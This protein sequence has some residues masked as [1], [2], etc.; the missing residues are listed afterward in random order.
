MDVVQSH[1]FL[2]QHPFP[3]C[4]NHLVPLVIQHRFFQ[5]TVLSHSFFSKIIGAISALESG[6]RE[7]TISLTRIFSQSIPYAFQQLICII[8]YAGNISVLSRATHENN[9]HKQPGQL[10][11]KA[12]HL[13]HSYGRDSF[14]LVAEN[15]IF[16]DQPENSSLNYI[17]RQRAAFRGF[18]FF[19]AQNALRFQRNLCF[20]SSG[21]VLT[22]HHQ[23]SIWLQI[24]AHFDP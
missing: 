10:L 23:S 6:H 7:T 22:C 18:Q 9:N 12:F 8:L 13:Y 15:Q 20:C 5:Q 17:N 21:Q 24:E 16:A 4:F 1:P 2:T 14:P 11:K 19:L 3:I